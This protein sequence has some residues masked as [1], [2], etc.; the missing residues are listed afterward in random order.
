[1]F[2]YILVYLSMKNV[3]E[4]DPISRFALLIDLLNGDGSLNG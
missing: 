1:M 2:D 4:F 3:K